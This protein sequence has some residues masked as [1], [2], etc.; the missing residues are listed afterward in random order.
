MTERPSIGFRKTLKRILKPQLQSVGLYELK[1]HKPWF[2][3]ECSRFFL[4]IESRLKCSGYK[5][6]TKTIQII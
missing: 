6:Q 4:I 2:D 3:E 1:Q 5:I